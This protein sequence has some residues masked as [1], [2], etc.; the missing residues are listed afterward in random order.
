MLRTRAGAG[1]AY[2]APTSWCRS[3]PSSGACAQTA[4]N[5]AL[6]GTIKTV[7]PLGPQVVYEVEIAGG[8]SVKSQP[9]ARSRNRLPLA[10]GS[11]IGLAPVSAA[12]CHVFPAE[13]S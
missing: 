11:T 6:A 9:V 4:G 7:M 2:P 5:A 3:V 8:M 10:S 12:A 1:P 13:A